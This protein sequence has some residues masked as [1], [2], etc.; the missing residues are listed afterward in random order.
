MAQEL[1][2]MAASEARGDENQFSFQMQHGRL[3]MRISECGGCQPLCDLLERNQ[4]LIF[5]WLFDVAAKTKMPAQWDADLMQIVCGKDPDAAALA[6][7]AHIRSGMTET[8]NAISERYRNKLTWMQ[9]RS[10]V[11]T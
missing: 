7:G 3:H 8:Q 10:K 6:M 11:S 4:V 9:R 5:N 1:D 2:S